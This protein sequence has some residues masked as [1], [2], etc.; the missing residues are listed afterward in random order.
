MVYRKIYEWEKEEWIL[1]QMKKDEKAAE[2]RKRRRY[3]ERPK[4]DFVPKGLTIDLEEAYTKY[5]QQEVTFRP[6][7]SDDFTYM[8]RLLE[9]WEKKSIP[10]VL[11]KGRPDAAYAIAMGLCKHLPLLIMRD[12][13]RDYV[14]KYKSRINKL[15]LASFTA[16][17]DSVKIW[18]NEE[19]REYVFTYIF[20]HLSQFDYSKYLQR[21]LRM[22][23]PEEKI[24]GE[25]IHIEREMD[26]EEERSVR[27]AEWKREEEQ[28]KREEEERRRAEMEKEARSI[29]PLNMDYEQRIFHRRNIDMNGNKICRLMCDEYENIERLAEKGDYQEAALRFMQMMKSMC[30]HFV[31]DCHWEYFDDMYSPECVVNA[32]VGLFERLAKEGKLPEEVNGYLHEAWKEIED[33][34]SYR[35][36]GMP[37][38]ALPF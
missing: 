29:I 18:N 20:A 37:R 36:Y 31:M 26:E 32:M 21:K 38:D 14:D 2:V 3:M 6:E 22:L 9:R 28:R 13:I 16:L 23:A 25:P 27:E 11:G 7:D 4:I 30:R 1:E 33:T 8:L 24:V 10:Q 34:E 17:V 15:I 12:D 35:N 19:K 5:F